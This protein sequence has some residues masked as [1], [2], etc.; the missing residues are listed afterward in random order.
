MKMGA[1]SG[2]H[3]VVLIIAATILAV[4]LSMHLV[5]PLPWDEQTKS[6]AARFMPF[7][8]GYLLIAAI[9]AARR[10]TWA[11]LSMP[12]PS[13]RRGEVIAVSLFKGIIYTLATGG[14]VALWFWA[15]GGMTGFE[16]RMAAQQSN[17]RA[18]ELALT[19]IGV[20][21]QL[22]F[23]SAL[24]P[25]LEE[26]VFRGLLYPA[27]AQRWGWFRSMLL[28]SA[29]FAI[30][31]PVFIAAF[32]SSIIFVCLYRRTGT[33]WAPIAAHMASNTLLW[34]P[35]MGQVV[36]LRDYE[37]RSDLASWWFHFLCLA[38]CAVAIPWYVWKARDVGAADPQEAS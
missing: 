36:F 19:P 18:L 17:E 9:P 22:L 20:A 26:L 3:I 35:L 24:G 33:L 2:W 29:V 31:H 14:A 28:T 37:S 27:W 15:S 7:A 1:L 34:A 23:F 30:Y 32:V 16:N 21:Q 11:R 13:E 5:R 38:V 12:I 10:W 6:F 8:F 25:I 4:P